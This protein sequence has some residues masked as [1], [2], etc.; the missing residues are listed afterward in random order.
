MRLIY[1]SDGVMCIVT[2]LMHIAAAF[3]K[4][5]VVVAGGREPWWWEGYTQENRLF[6]LRHGMPGWNP[7]ANDNYVEHRY[8]HTLGQLPCCMNKGC[9]KT[10]IEPN[11]D[12][13]QA[14]SIVGGRRIPRCMEL[15]TAEHVVRAVESYYSK[16][17]FSNL[18]EVPKG[19]AAP[20]VLPPPP[21]AAMPVL[22]EPV[23][24]IPTPEPILA[25]VRVCLYL[26]DNFSPLTYLQLLKERWTGN[27]ELM[28]LSRHI[29]H[30]LEDWCL[31][32]KA[33]LAKC[34]DRAA[35]MAR[36]MYLNDQKWT[37]WL[38]YP[39]LPKSKD[40]WDQLMRRAGG[41]RCA[42]GIVY[43]HRLTTDMVSVFRQMPWNK[44]V[45]FMSM[46][47]VHGAYRTFYPGAGFWML[48]TA[49][50]QD[51]KFAQWAKHPMVEVA[52]GEALH[53]SAV[54]LNEVGTMV[55]HP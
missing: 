31:K 48:P 4:P 20:V 19:V 5:C 7:P 54:P 32:S 47:L 2:C 14:P 36:V 49:F 9:W 12:S 29:S 34:D 13:C 27:G 50:L 3:N 15:I 45:A 43:W 8:L 24:D 46:G 30:E 53:Q 55:L 17:P 21:I 38:E 28:V 26:A 6:N 25:G 52:L 18:I 22:T 41:R 39:W 11:R 51:I 35:A 37:V 42:M 33:S 1:H 23:P 10:K 44:N 40:I 16:Q